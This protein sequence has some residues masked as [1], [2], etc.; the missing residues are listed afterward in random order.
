[1]KTYER[2]TGILLVAISAAA[3]GLMPVFAKM[4]Y[5]AGTGTYTLLFLRF[6]T[7]AVF[8]FILMRI[9]ALPLP[10]GKDIMAFLLLGAIGN[11]GMSFCYFTAL[12]YASSSVV[13]LLLYTYPALVM[14]GSVIFFGEQITV[15]KILALVLALTGAFI[16]IGAGFRTNAA[17][18]FLSVMAAVFYSIYI[19]VSSR[20]VKEGMSIQASA[21]VMLGAAVV[22]GIM[23][24]VLEFTPPANIQGILAV[25]LIAM[26]STVLAFW[27]FL[28]GMEKTGPST[29]ALIST[30]EPVVTVLASI[31]IL[32]E[33]ITMRTISGGILVLAA[34]LVTTVSRERACSYNNCNTYI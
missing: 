25:V 2:N 15:Q 6:L 16:I 3:F 11:A 19:L 20:I 18:F 13:A 28:T 30:L 22:F 33:E 29:A 8:M 10:S 34:L 23:N 4:A 12:K 9:R 7:A 27:S 17:G 1:M 31:L 21:F 14:A 24:L 26:V 5:T 32:S